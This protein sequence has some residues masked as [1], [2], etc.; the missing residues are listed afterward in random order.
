MA[1]CEIN[2]NSFKLHT[3]N[4]VIKLISKSGDFIKDNLKIKREKDRT[5]AF[6]MEKV[7]QW[8]QISKEK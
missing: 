2:L 5:I 4:I 7:N 8:K 3:D 6:A 1:H